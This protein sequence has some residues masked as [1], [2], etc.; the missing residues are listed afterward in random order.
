MVD[1]VLKSSMGQVI[2]LALTEGWSREKSHESMLPVITVAFGCYG[3]FS[4]ID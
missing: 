3:F 1:A 4:P 2:G